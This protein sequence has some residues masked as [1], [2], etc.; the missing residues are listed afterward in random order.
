MHPQF[1]VFM[2]IETG[3]AQLL[4]AQIESERLHQMQPTAG[5]GGQPDDIAGIRR[6]FR[7]N[8]D[9]FEHMS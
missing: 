9:D 8:Q 5:I 3:A 7:F 4:V 2:V 6:D 1:G